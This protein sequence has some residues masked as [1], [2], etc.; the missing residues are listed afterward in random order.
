MELSGAIRRVRAQG[1]RLTPQ[2]IAILRALIAAGG[3]VSA[4]EVL[5]RVQ[6]AVPCMSLDTVYRNLTMLTTTGLV[7]RTNLQTQGVARFE[8]QG[9]G[10]HHHVVCLACGRS[11]CVE[12]CPMPEA[13]QA[14]FGP[15]GFQVVSHAFE[16]YGYC[17]EC[18]G[19][20]GPAPPP[21]G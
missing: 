18:R 20:T 16:V 10:H 15:A 8:F 19:T 14:L 7:A 21:S 12:A 1:R 5:E 17:G 9:E 3:P 4:Q 13:V 11:A 6:T 2:R